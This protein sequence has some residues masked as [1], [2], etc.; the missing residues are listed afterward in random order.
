MNPHYA[1]GSPFSPAVYQLSGTDE[2][3]AG[4]L[5]KVCQRLWLGLSLV[6]DEARRG[7]DVTAALDFLK[8]MALEGSRKSYQGMTFKEIGDFARMLKMMVRHE[9]A[10]PTKIVLIKTK[11]NGKERIA[12]ESHGANIGPCIEPGA[13]ETKAKVEAAEKAAD[14]AFYKAAEYIRGLPEET[15][16]ERICK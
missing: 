2:G 4:D 8:R 15:I 10:K 11:I 9:D 7:G 12:T 14:E 16:V 3:D 5:K 13:D 6:Q 1:D